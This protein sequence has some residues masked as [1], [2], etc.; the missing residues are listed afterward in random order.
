MAQLKVVFFALRN[1]FFDD[2]KNP[3]R[4]ELSLTERLVKLIQFLGERDIKVIFHTNDLWY[5]GEEKK[6]LNIFLEEISGYKIGYYNSEHY[7]LM[8]R[9]P[10]KGSIPYILEQ[11]GLELNEAIYICGNDDDWQ[12]CINAKVLCIKANW[13]K[14]SSEI[15]YGIAFDD[16]TTLARFIDIFCIKANKEDLY[17]YQDARLTYYTLSPFSTLKPALKLYSES[18][19]S[20]AKQLGSKIEPSFWLM[21][22]ISKMYFSGIYKNLDAIVVFPGHQIGSGNAVMN[23]DLDT[24][25]KCFRI[26]YLI[27]SLIRH[28]QSLKSQNARL[29]GNGGALNIYNHL[30]TLYINRKPNTYNAARARVS[31]Y[32]YKD[33]NILLIDDFVTEGYSLDAAKLLLEATGAKVICMSWLK[34]INT[35]IKISRNPLPKNYPIYSIVNNAQSLFPSPAPYTICYT[36]IIHDKYTAGTSL[37]QLYDDFCE[38]NFKI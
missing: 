18:A 33:K 15:K 8:P 37:A 30:N 2:R 9:K 24:F 34:T 22:L 12:A 4:F 7:P 13:I 6:P 3:K 11:E 23:D 21:L 17:F 28:T 38:W 35:S 27:N 32:S 31:N 29:Q 16:M 20:T 19:K 36:D 14:A 25:L 10:L 1:V 5:M 26:K